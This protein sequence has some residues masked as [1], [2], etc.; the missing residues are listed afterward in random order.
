[1][2][3]IKV[4]L[5]KE[6]DQI[7]YLPW[8]SEGDMNHPDAE[9]GF[10]VTTRTKEGV[11]PEALCRYWRRGKPGELPTVANGEWTPTFS[12]ALFK[13]VPDSVIEGWFS[14]QEAARD[15]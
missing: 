14:D 6:G 9:L 3:E 8:H 10:V 7:V 2:A 4:P 5:L 1:M 11:P 12:L 13:S 15:E